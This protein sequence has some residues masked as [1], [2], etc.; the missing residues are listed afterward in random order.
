[1]PQ[2]SR[3]YAVARVRAQAR[4]P[5]NAAQMERLAG[6]SGYAEAVAALAEMGWVITP[7]E[8]A[9]RVAARVV[10]E[11]CAR[12]KALSPNPTLTDAFLLRHDAQNL[13]ALVKAR[14]LG[15]SPEGHSG[16]GTLDVEA[17]RHAVMDRTYARLPAPLQAAMESLEKRLALRDEARQ[18]DVAIDKAAFAMSKAMAQK[19]GSSAAVAYFTERADLQN[20]IS[21]L[22]LAAL[23]RPHADF[24]DEL[25]PGG[26]VTAAQW[27]AMEGRKEHLSALLTGLGIEVRQALQGAAADARFIPALEKAMDDRLLTHFRPY[28]FS[29]DAVEVLIGD[30]LAREREAAAVRLI[31]TAKLNGFPQ[32]VIRERL[33]DA[34]GG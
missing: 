6:A 14:M 34:Y 2:M 30:L 19:S 9:G 17:L 12:L 20:A 18:V 10:E 22:R 7:G 16:S 31:L 25:L 26:R 1:M 23:G 32:E 8:D 33:R 11:T 28:R 24:M 21:F 13:K 4:R 5:L 15:Q 3:P 29:P 27:K